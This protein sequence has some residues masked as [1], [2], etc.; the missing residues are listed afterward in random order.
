MKV[1]YKVG[2][3][4]LVN[5]E[6]YEIKNIRF[7]MFNGDVDYQ[8]GNEKVTGWVPDTLIEEVREV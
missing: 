3:K 8:L 7:G 1:E 5:G 4:A 2:Q 6:W